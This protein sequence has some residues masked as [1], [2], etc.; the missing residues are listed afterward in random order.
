MNR[1]ILIGVAIAAAAAMAGW[2]SWRWADSRGENM[3]LLYGN[4][5][6]REVNLGF[7]VAGRIEAMMFDEGDRVSAGRLLAS[8]DKQPFRNE[9]AVQ[10]AAIAQQEA[11]LQKLEAGTRA[12]EIEQARATVAARKATLENARGVFQRQQEL[13]RRDFASK[14]VYENAATQFREAEAQL[15]SAEE[16]LK[17]AIAGP[18]REDIA[19][20]RAAL[21]AAKAQ[22]QVAETALA[23]AELKAPADGV[24]LTRAV[25]PGAIVAAG[26]TVYG[27]SLQNPVWVR[28]YVSEPRLGAIYPGMRIEVLTDT[29]PGQPY[30]GQVGFISP[31]AEF[32]PKTVETPEL[33]ADLV[34]RFRVLVKNPDA[35]LRQGM[36]VTL[37][38][39][40]QPPSPAVASGS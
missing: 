34:Y 24:I 39:P 13:E 27:L 30:Q 18:R 23:D 4:V 26:A 5:E 29:R 3:L 28:A 33:R 1:R 40:E 2:Y 31:V 32:T 21:D 16:A 14:Q 22:Q 36:P 12:E 25:E 10:T 37:R 35:A 17:L 11:N 38:I 8:L 6:I 20:A 9:L 15:K 19:A 7:R